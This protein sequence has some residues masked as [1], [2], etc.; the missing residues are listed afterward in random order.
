M[1]R[2]RP[3]NID[4]RYVND[5]PVAVAGAASGNEDSTIPVALLGTD[6]DGTIASVTVTALPANGTL[7]KADGTW[8]DTADLAEAFTAAGV[9]LSRPVITSCGSGITA[10]CIA[11]ALHLLGKDDVALYDGSWTEWG[12]D[13]D[14]PKASGEAEAA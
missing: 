8:K 12:S 13:P 5:A 11:F 14:T 1:V 7:F 2:P 10:C 4:R 3:A 9:D 6:I